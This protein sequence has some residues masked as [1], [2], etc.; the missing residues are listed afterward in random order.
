MCHIRDSY[1]SFPYHFQLFNSL[2]RSLIN[3]FVNKKWDIMHANNLVLKI[4]RD[5]G[6]SRWPVVS[7]RFIHHL[8]TGPEFLSK[9]Y[10]NIISI[11]SVIIYQCAYITSTYV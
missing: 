9:V 11:N 10:N 4:K 7:L 2:I 8:L 1:N 6:C 3:S 5:L